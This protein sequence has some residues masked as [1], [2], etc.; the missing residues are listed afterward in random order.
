MK[1]IKKCGQ[2]WVCGFQMFVVC[3]FQIFGNLPEIAEERSPRWCMFMY[4]RILF[5]YLFMA[6]KN[7]AEISL[8]L[9]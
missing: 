3:G 6:D 2:I 5:L 1:G 8:F 7:F 4:D 9:Y